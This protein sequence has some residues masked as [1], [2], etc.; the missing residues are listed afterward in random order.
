MQDAWSIARDAV[1][2][3]GGKAREYFSGALKMAWDN[4]KHRVIFEY[5]WD[6][7]GVS[8]QRLNVIREDF[9]KI[10]E[11]KPKFN[12]DTKQFTVMAT[13][14]EIA[15]LKNLEFR[16]YGDQPEVRRFIKFIN[17]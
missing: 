6:V 10:F 9:K 4:A 1:V 16:V 15:K 3:F 8:K 7:D 2:K 5:L 11:Q 12:G 14:S 13:D 17:I